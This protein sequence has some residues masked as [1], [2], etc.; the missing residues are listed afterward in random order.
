VLVGESKEFLYTY[1]Y[2]S[3]YAGIVL[4][5][6]VCDPCSIPSQNGS[7]VLEKEP[8]EV[9]SIFHDYNAEHSW[10]MPCQGGKEK[11]GFT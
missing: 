10:E 11:E 2:M 9:V 5:S 6:C 4:S 7:V 8:V 3:V 1:T